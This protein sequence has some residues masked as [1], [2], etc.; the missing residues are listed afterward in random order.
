MES[1][2]SIVSP[3]V[4]WE[5]TYGNTPNPFWVV[6]RDIWQQSLAATKRGIRGYL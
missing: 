3:A 5:D 4:G 1:V 2:K 6:E